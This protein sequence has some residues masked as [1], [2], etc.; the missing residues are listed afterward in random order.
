MFNATL[1]QNFSTLRSIILFSKLQSRKQEAFIVIVYRRII[2]IHNKSTFGT[3]HPRDINKQEIP[4]RGLQH[5]KV[6]L[7]VIICNLI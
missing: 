4:Y 2:H 1:N 7:C 3:A 6:L 5:S